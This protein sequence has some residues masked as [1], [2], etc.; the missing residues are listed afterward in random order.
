[1]R[2]QRCRHV[3][4]WCL[5]TI[6]TDGAGKGAYSDTVAGA[7]ERSTKDQR[8]LMWLPHGQA[9]PS[10]SK[11][12]PRDLLTR[13]SQRRSEMGG[14]RREFHT[15]V[16]RRKRT[17]SIGPRYCDDLGS[18]VTHTGTAKPPNPQVGDRAGAKRGEAPRQ[19]G[20]LDHD[21][22][23]R[24]RERQEKREHRG[25]NRPFRPAWKPAHGLMRPRSVDFGGHT[26][27]G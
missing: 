21:H 25:D 23:D 7:Q 9:R 5:P 4:R 11:P 6:P 17:S 16:W 19:P 10:R 20:L 27:Q 26:R 18:G 13:T 22:K 12:D 1:M 24:H 8:G 3:G 15:A 2:Q 14:N